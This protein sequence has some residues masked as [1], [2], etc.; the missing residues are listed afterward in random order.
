MVRVVYIVP[1]YYPAIGG[2]REVIKRVIE[3]IVPIR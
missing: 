3:H 1:F 2:V